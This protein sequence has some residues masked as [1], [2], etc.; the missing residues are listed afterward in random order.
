MSPRAWRCAISATAAR[1][2]EEA[3]SWWARN[4]VA[5]PGR[6]VTELAACLKQ[7][8]EAPGLGSPY[9]HPDL[10][11]LRRRLLAV[12]R[13]HVYYTQ[14]PETRTVVVHAVWHAARGELPRLG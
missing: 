14:R 6:F 12:T 10:P 8:R 11:G 3:A 2:I 9:W 13:Y 5:A 1:Q 7:L 4:R